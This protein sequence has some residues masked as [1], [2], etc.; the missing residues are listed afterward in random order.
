MKI[1]II[2]L[3]KG[4]IR[5]NTPWPESLIIGLKKH[6][7][8]V[9]VT[10]NKNLKADLNIIWGITSVHYKKLRAKNKPV[11]VVEQGFLGNRKEWTALGFNGLNGLAS[12]HTDNVS[13]DRW[14]KYWKSGM[15]PWNPKGDYTLIMG[16]V[17]SDSSLYGYDIYQWASKVASQLKGEV[18]FR[19]HPVFEAG[20]RLQGIPLLKGSLEDALSGAKALVTYS[21]NS[22]VDAV[23]NGKPTL[24]YHEGSMAWDVTSHDITQPLYTGDREEW[25]KKLS[26]CQWLPEELESGVAWEHLKQFM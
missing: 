14:N 5:G 3:G 21:S 19:D 18:Y 2:T 25:G 6:G 23:Y 24:S 12:Y 15:K 1:H 11:L 26:Y 20:S 7:E 22:A 8:T 4:Q 9:T 17:P 16:Q 13:D 10:R